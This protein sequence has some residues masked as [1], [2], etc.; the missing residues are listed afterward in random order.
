MAVSDYKKEKTSTI[1]VVDRLKESLVSEGLIT[2]D[3]LEAAE[4]EARQKNKILGRVLVDSG[5]V[6]EEKLLNFIGEKVHIPYVDISKYTIDPNVLKRIP[7]RI[8][9]SYNILPLFEIEKVLT[10]A[11]SDPLDIISCDK[12]SEVIKYEIDPVLAPDESIKEAINLWYSLGVSKKELINKLAGE[13]TSIVEEKEPE[14][15]YAKKLDEIRLRK[16]AEAP[17]VVK[18]VNSIVAQAVLEGASD[19]HIE[20]KKSILEVRFRIGGCRV[21]LKA[22]FLSKFEGINYG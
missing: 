21:Q 22:F 8:A 19:I 7:E 18:L 20:P 6:T 5:Y 14:K 9:R 3:Q 1:K 13:L 11:M 4:K 17:P 2:Q 10:V 12:I 16:E 15:P